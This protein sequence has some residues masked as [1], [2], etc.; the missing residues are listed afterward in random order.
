MLKKAVDSKYIFQIFCIA[1]IILIFLDSYQVFNIPLSWIGNGLIL[2]I[3]LCIGI[4]EKVKTN[5]VIAVITITALLPTLINL[6]GKDYDL[7][8]LILRVFS[9]LTFVLVMNVI[10]KTK[11][12]S[13]ILISLEK[14]Y[15]FIGCFYFIGC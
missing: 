11:R 7:Q 14:A 8:Y 5:Q 2:T 1:S 10:I 4:I 3:F 6:F 15:I 9:F 13:S 12:L